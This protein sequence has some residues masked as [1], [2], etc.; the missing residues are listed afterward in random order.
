MDH[1]KWLWKRQGSRAGKDLKKSV[2][3]TD[4]YIHTHTHTHTHTH[5]R[6]YDGGQNISKPTL[7]NRAETQIML[8]AVYMYIYIYSKSHIG[9]I[10]LYR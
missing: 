6:E 8:M 7:A 5:I 1:R 3:K 10:S 4:S 9:R 2:Q